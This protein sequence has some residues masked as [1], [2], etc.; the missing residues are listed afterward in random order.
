[1]GTRRT[2]SLRG[3]VERE[4][5][6]PLRRGERFSQKALETHDP[7]CCNHSEH[8]GSA[9]PEPKQHDHARFQRAGRLKG[10]KQTSWYWPAMA[11][12]SLR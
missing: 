7:D 12:H 9:E 2:P 4:T 1:M 5:L 11:L 3:D 8:N 10:K 6:Q